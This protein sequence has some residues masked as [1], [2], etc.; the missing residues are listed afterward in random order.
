MITNGNYHSQ[1][2]YKV[3]TSL[4]TLANLGISSSSHL[5]KVPAAEFPDNWSL[6][7]PA[8]CDVSPRK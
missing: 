1:Y 8:P 4:T 5:N 3:F 6:N 2:I 7:D